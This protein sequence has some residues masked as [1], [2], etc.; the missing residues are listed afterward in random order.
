LLLVG[1]ASPGFD[2]QRLGGEGVERIDYVDEERLWSVMAACDVCVSLRS[3]TMGE[4]SGSAI[5][6]LALGKPLL[7]SDVGWFAELPDDAAMKVPVDEDEVPALAASLELLAS[8]EAT[9]HAMSDAARAHVRREHDVHGVAASYVAALEEAA[10]GPVVADAVVRE[11]ALAAAEVGIEPGTPFA[12]ELGVRLDELGFVQD[13]RPQL[14]PPPQ[15]S[16]LARVP[17]W[18]WLVAL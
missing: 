3:P 11:I 13:G 8:S 4:T 16:R 1:P 14:A 6:A 2:M 17:A 9:R 10:G 5:R 18:L 7:V 12:Q 15:P